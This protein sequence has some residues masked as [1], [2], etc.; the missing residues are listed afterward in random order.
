MHVPSLVPPLMPPSLKVWGATYPPDPPCFRRLCSLSLFASFSLLS[1]SLSTPFHL[2]ASFFSSSTASESALVKSLAHGKDLCPIPEGVAVVGHIKYFDMAVLPLEP[3]DDGV[4]FG[5][6]S[7]P[8][9]SHRSFRCKVLHY[10][11]DYII[12]GRTKCVAVRGQCFTVVHLKP[13]NIVCINQK[14]PFSKRF[15]KSSNCSSVKD[16]PL[17]APL[18]ETTPLN[19]ASPLLGGVS[20]SGSQLGD[21]PPSGPQLG[22]A[23]PSEPQLHLHC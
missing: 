14:D 11:S 9:V 5:V 7:S 8:L 2:V 19:E 13:A 12:I 4:C 23:P 1:V 6:T 20:P 17:V 15:S 16:A 22:D 18:Y 21:A 3:V 10:R